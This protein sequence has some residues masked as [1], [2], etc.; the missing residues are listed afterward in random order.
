MKNCLSLL[1]LLVSGFVFNQFSAQIF[2]DKEAKMKVDGSTLVKVNK[3]RNSIDYVK[4]SK[5]SRI[6]ELENLDWLT[7]K[8]LKINP[9]F[10]FQFEKKETDK[11][12]FTHFKYNQYYKN[13]LVEYGVYN[14]HVERGLIESA[15][16]EFY[17]DISVSINPEISKDSAFVSALNVV[18]SERILVQ[19]GRG[20]TEMKNEGKLLILPVKNGFKLAYKFDIYSQKPL[21]RVYVYIDAQTGQKIKEIN[22][23]HHTDVTGTANTAYNGTVSITTDQV[24]ESSFR[25]RS[26]MGFGGVSTFNMNNGTNYGSATDFTDTDNIWNSTGSDMYA[27]D[28]HFGAQATYNYFFNRFGRNSYDN[29]GASINSYVHYD[30]DFV[31]AFWDGTQMTYGD[32]D[33][34]DYTAL[35]SIDVVGHEITHAVTEYTAGLVYA[36]ESGAL[37]ESFSDCFG[38]AIDYANN[39]TTANFDMGDQFALNGIPFRGMANP[40]DY[41]NPDTY[42]GTYWNNPNE[43]HNNSGVQNFWFYLISMGGSGVNDLGDS[44][45]INAIG[46]DK[47]GEIAYRNLST[48]LTP[49]STHEDA[50]FY[51]I[52]AA[53]DLYGE[54]SEEVIQVTNAWFAVGV[55][56]IYSNDVVSNFIASQNY[57]CT[58]PA[59]VTFTNTSVNGSTYFWEFGDGGT[60]ALTSPTHTYSSAGTYS[61]SLQVQGTSACSSSDTL[62]LSNLITVSNGGGPASSTC[63]PATV[64]YCCNVGVSNLSFAT[65][66]KTSSN[67]TEGYRDFSCSDATT[68]TA[69]DI[70]PISITTGSTYNENVKV[71]IDYNNDGAFNNT[72]ELVFTSINKLINHSGYVS[73]SNSAVLNTPLRMRIID[74]RSTYTIADACYAPQNG[75]VEDYTITF[76]ANVLPPEADFTANMTTINTGGTINFTD[77][78]QHSPTSWSWTFTGASSTSSSLQNPTITYNT[79]GIFPVKLVVTNSFGEDSITKTAYV[80]V[81]NAI[82]LCSGITSTTATSGQ[83][84]DSGG[85]TGNYQNSEF[86]TLLIDPGCALSVTLAFTQFSG[87]SCCDYFRV[88]N[89]I[90]NSAP[91]IGTFVG[92]TIP[93]SVTANSGT[94][95]I[96]WSSDGSVIGSGFQATWSSVVGTGV[97]PV[98]DFSISSSNPA[99]ATPVQFTDLSTEVPVS[100]L[101]NFGDGNTA[102]V[103]NPSHAFTNAGT[104]TVTLIAYNCV[105]SD[106]I[107][108]TIT[109]QGAP[110]ITL[111]PDSIAVSLAACSDSIT[112]P[113]YVLNT[114]TGDLSFNVSGNSTNSSPN[115]LSFNHGVDM[116]EEYINTISAI[117][118]YYTDYTLINTATT[119]PTTL[120]TLLEDVDVLLFPE[121]ESGTSSVFTSIATVVQNF[122]N[123]GGTVIVCGSSTTPINLYSMGLFSGTFN[124]F[125]TG[126]CIIGDTTIDIA[127]NVN[128]SFS[129]SNASFT[130]NFTNTDVV[131]VATLNSDDLVAYR[132]IGDGKAVFVGF[133]YYESE[134]NAKMLLSNAVRYH[135]S[136]VLDSWIQIEQ[137]VTTVSPGD[138]A[139]VNVTF[140]STD[141]ESGV[142]TSNIVF[143]S[144]DPLNS[145]D[146]L[147]VTM[148]VGDNPCVGFDFVTPSDCSGIVNFENTSLN[149]SSWTWS[150]GD[151]DVS[152]L[153]NPSHTYANAGTYQVELIVCNNGFCDSMT[154][155][156]TIISTT[157]PVS[158]F[159][160]PQ[161]TG[162]CCGMGIRNVTI[163]TINNTSA[164]GSIGYQDYSCTINTNLVVGESY[165]LN[166]MTGT[167]YNENVVAWIDY[168]NDGVFNTTDEK[169][170]TSLNILTNHTGT[171]TIPATTFLNT[172]LRMRIGSEYYSNSV[173]LS[174]NN[175]T[176][177]QFEDYSI[178]IAPNT[179]PPVV[180]FSVSGL[181]DCDGIAQ[182]TDQTQYA[183]SS[184]TWYFGDGNTSNL[185]N[186]SHTYASS[187]TYQVELVV[188][189]N[190]SC[191]SMTQSINYITSFGPIDAFCS[192]QTTG[193][194]CGMGIRN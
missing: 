81:V 80:N 165:T 135:N 2:K 51:S 171:I 70:I 79:L 63:S 162:N 53:I 143:N 187:G 30:F 85:P 101:W 173:P 153:E 182:F 27:Y 128:T 67:A 141:L 185:Q 174:C 108:Q 177:G 189:N 111:H 71:W 167:Q 21:K 142:Y 44:Y 87:E 190:I 169:V 75:Q 72:N 184:W 116:T 170:F 82:N 117:N 138:S 84:Y 110:I 179:N 24:S 52:Q 55:G 125:V 3:N 121:N 192:P 156:L 147:S 95:F 124:T 90:N 109:T 13:L 40:N 37:N 29:A 127:N 93:G 48:Y 28:A 16:G 130:H 99:L 73:T 92:T 193:N 149:S 134:N 14:V 26:S 150:F 139:L 54:C 104:Y 35:T 157:G 176:Y 148:T 17:S 83:L 113:M 8:V 23:I 136:N 106:T 47:A 42:G 34:I 194:C 105:S 32:G 7:K 154:Q 11:K 119:D 172:P 175:V 61:V 69:G 18:N 146:S 107:T 89:G 43:V 62:I 160:S 41:G 1:L 5:T 15:N 60:S 45:S 97:P 6:S 36:D 186:P 68:V 183:P 56:E 86:C 132:N 133:D 159:C 126:T 158:A 64:A 168:N 188:C 12:G 77:L 100:W 20:L 9:D 115:V 181:T 59:N 191:D 58:L 91:L 88:Y 78:T 66:N 151:G 161:T 39:P 112:V 96:Q 50:R 120:E 166:V 57:F 74:D 114:G 140:Y 19:N 31:N 180:D 164:D 103:Q 76:I 10:S 94:M 22:R 4:L 25:L 98:A 65:I 178:I 118:Q 163:N 38:V 131:S 46:I 145:M 123:N 102:T 129:S 137:I 144:N 155:A 33:G 49:N 152:S 122:A